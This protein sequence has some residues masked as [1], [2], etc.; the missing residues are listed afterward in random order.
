MPAKIKQTG[1]A[2]FDK[3]EN[4]LYFIASNP[5]V[6]ANTTTPYVL[7]AV[8]ELNA[9]DPI[10]DVQPLIDAKS[11]IFLDSGIFNLTMTHARKHN[12]HMNDALGLPPTAIDGF[13]ELYEKYTTIVRALEPYLWGYI[14]LDQGGMDNK[15]KT[16]AKLEAD[17]LRP[18]PVYHPLNDGWDYFDELASQYDRICWGNIVKASTKERKRF[19]ATMTERKEKYPHLWIHLLGYTPSQ[20]LCAYPSESC[21][22]STWL[23][24]LRW[25]SSGD[26]ACLKPIGSFPLEFKYD[27]NVDADHAAGRDSAAMVSG[28]MAHVQCLN[29]KHF[30]NTYYTGK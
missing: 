1:G 13:H 27:Y 24:S 12:V 14:E 2:L 11:K 20:Y 9:S 29:L 18:I 7:I 28:F 26:T 3:T 25:Q 15:K 19:L 17:G 6:L 10:K 22:S 8:N 5:S 16:R 23:A 4:P 30:Y 21:D